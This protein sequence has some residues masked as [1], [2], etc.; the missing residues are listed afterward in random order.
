MLDKSALRA[1]MARRGITQKEL[2]KKIGISEKTFITRMKNGV[3]G[4]DEA[5]II[6]KTLS[7]ANPQ[8]I[9]FAKQ[10]N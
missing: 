3:F 6:I 10:V 5:E 7:I 1:E 9:F 8:E 4:T 2:A